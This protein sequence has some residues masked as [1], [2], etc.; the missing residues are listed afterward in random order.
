VSNAMR[1]VIAIFLIVL[2][3]GGAAFAI[4]G[5]AFS[6]VACVKTPPDWVYYVLVAA[7]VVTLAAGVVPAIM[8][9]RRAR[10]ARIAVVLVL[11]GILACGGYAGYF[12]LLGSYC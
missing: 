5:G 7:G 3:I 4:F 9:L 1:W 8:L 6:T 12:V 2:G 11:G 10:G